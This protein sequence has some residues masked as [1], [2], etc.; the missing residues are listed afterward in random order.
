MHTLFP[1]AAASA[2]LLLAAPALAEDLP[3]LGEAEVVS[4]GHLG[5][6]G[7]VAAPGGT[8]L[9][10]DVS[11]KKVLRFDPETGETSV[12]D[13]ESGGANGLGFAGDALVRCE[14]ESRRVTLTR[15][16]G[17]EPVVLVDAF[18]GD[19]FN[20][21][22]DLIVLPDGSGLFFT[23]P[24]YGDRHTMQMDT[25]G[26]YALG[27]PLVEGMEATRVVGDLTRPNGVTISAD[28]ATVYVAD[29]GERVIHAYRV[30]PGV[31]GGAPGL[32][33]GRVFADVFAYGNPD[34]MA[35]DRSGRL[36]V[37]LFETGKLLVLS[38]EGEPLSLTD[39]GERTSNVCLDL[40]E[41]HAYVTAGG[42]LLRFRIDAA[43]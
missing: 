29:E 39:A 23:D 4:E 43:E 21:P 17:A 33:D 16:P 27:S 28:G 3:S 13:P 9:F 41:E 19:A 30:V 5:L 37:A 22:N 10:S 18:E 26:V 1:A 31:D 7:P 14:G 42:S 8:I 15:P 25:E 12:V 24:R 32:A 34:G 38:P 6:E 20:T 40:D 2:C 11:A 35:T 36:Y